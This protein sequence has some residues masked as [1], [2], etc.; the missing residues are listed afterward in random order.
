MLGRIVDKFTS[1]EHVVTVYR[2]DGTFVALVR[3]MRYYFIG[4]VFKLLAF[5]FRYKIL[6][7]INV[8]FVSSATMWQHR[9]GFLPLAI[10]G[11][12]THPL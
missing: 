4:A 9:A 6:F 1:F 11:N 8:S 2:L 3:V 10:S 12:F 5:I 7:V